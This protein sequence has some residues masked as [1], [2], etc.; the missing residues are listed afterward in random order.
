MI[1][2]AMFPPVVNSKM[3]EFTLQ[4]SLMC[5]AYGS[6]QVV[7]RDHTV[8]PVVYKTRPGILDEEPL[9]Q[10]ANWGLSWNLDGTSSIKPSLDIV[11]TKVMDRTGVKNA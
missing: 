4:L 11:A 6:V 3:N 1:N 8:V 10:A 7:L 5:Q 2:K 9:F